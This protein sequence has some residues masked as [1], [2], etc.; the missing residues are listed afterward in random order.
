MTKWL[1]QLFN[2]H[3]QHCADERREQH[4][5]EKQLREEQRH[6]SSCESLARENDRLVRDNERLMTLLLEKPATPAEKQIDVRDLKP[7]QTTKTPFIPSAIRRQ[8]LEQESRAAAK[9]QR[10]APKPDKV[11]DKDAELD[12]LEK[13]LDNVGKEREDQ[14]AS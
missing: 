9:I 13:E 12:A 4:E 5:L 14:K 10:D 7:I 11:I 2:P 1:H 8:I 3:C 6:C